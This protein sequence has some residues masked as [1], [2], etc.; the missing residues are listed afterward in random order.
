MAMGQGAG[1]AAALSV[2]HNTPIS[3]LDFAAVRS[4][5]IEQGAI[6][7]FDNVTALAVES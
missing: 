3:E 1:T 2:A 6:V 4:S 7:D 5:L